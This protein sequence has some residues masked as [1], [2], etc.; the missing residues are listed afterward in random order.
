MLKRIIFFCSF[1]FIISISFAQN[2]AKKIPLRVVLSAIENQHNVKFSFNSDVIK[3]KTCI[4]LKKRKPL[5]EKL[6]VLQ[7]Q[8]FLNFKQID[9]RYIVITEKEILKNQTVSGTLI[10]RK[11]REY[12]PFSSVLLK[13][14]PRGAISNELGE[15]SLTNVAS[16]QNIEVRGIGFNSVIIPVHKLLGV[17]N[18]LIELEE[19]QI[20]LEEVL[21]SDYL[22]QGIAK[23]QNG[24]IA[25]A[26]KKLGIL[27]GLIE[28]DVLWSLQMLPG[29]QSV[30]ETA[31]ELQIRG[32]SPDQNLILFD[33]IKMYQSGHFFGLISSFNPYITKQ[34]EVFRNGTSAKFGDRIGG[35][36]DI[37]SG[38][39]IPDF[40]AGVGV[41]LTHADAYVKTPL[42]NNKAGL[43]FSVRR[44]ITD[45]VQTITYKN[46]SESVFQNTRIINDAIQDQNKFSTSRN[47]F[48]FQDYNLKFLIDVSDKSSLSI[49]NLYNKNQLNYFSENSRFREKTQDDI[50]YKNTGSRM[51]WNHKPT[52]TF[53]QN[54]DV[55]VSA[56]Q[57]DSYGKRETTR[58]NSNDNSNREFEVVNHV[59]DHGFKYDLNY[60][61]NTLFQV[62]GGYQFSNTEIVYA[63]NTNLLIR[64][65]PVL[66]AMNS[67]NRTHAWFTELTFNG[68][69]TY[70]NLGVRG[71]HFST[72]KQM[73]FEPRLFASTKI[74]EALTIKTSGEIKNQVV[75]Q[76]IEY[77]NN[78]IGLE[79]S[80]WA[81]AN[82]QIPVLNSKQIGVGVLNKSKGWHVD[83]DFYKKKIAGTTLMT[84]T[85]ASTS[86]TSSMPFYI[87]GETDITGIDVLLKKRIGNYRSW[88]GYSNMR[89]R[90]RFKELNEGNMFKGMLSVPHALTWSHTYA[91]KHMEFS[92]GWKLRSGIP[93]TEANSTYLDASNNLRV[94]YEAVN[95]KR[96]P[97]YQKV[98][99]SSTYTFHFSKKKKIEGKLGLSLLNI[100]NTK[101]VLERTY[102]LKFVNSGADLEEQKLVKID[103]VSLGFTPNIVC[104]L[105]F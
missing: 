56:Y 88:I 25:L 68:A 16:D 72:S 32:S 38:D 2:T 10:N 84:E 64:N 66:S 51:N 58:N 12:I 93:Y 18:V 100:F 67:S 46:F 53:S 33:G 65:N 11:T 5:Q 101:N 59:N 57:F 75:R 28:P 37:S 20:A 7:K 35:V 77:R 41:N 13:G 54:I 69:K 22:T 97:N 50:T 43:L 104:R 44:S 90:Q 49:S 82:E 85:F 81:V 3:N 80:V 99:V 29:I 61:F 86:K 95:A 74:T 89:T 94:S 9:T 55:H 96:L 98:D 73:Y 19:D 87:S 30:S 45:W 39:T 4:P 63:Y 42:F 24:A 62:T 31:S 83:V 92:M 26:P 17:T 102:E 78:G 91:L 8:T 60:Q 27:P 23:K 105:R 1:L 47:D 79:N 76:I 52:A 14:T 103:R 70:M 6:E 15:F 71:N 40:E 48:Y 21:I 36:L 34:I